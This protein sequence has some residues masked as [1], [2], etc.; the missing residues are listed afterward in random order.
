MGGRIW[1]ESEEETTGATFHVRLPLTVPRMSP[2]SKGYD[3]EEDEEDEE[4]SLFP[5]HQ[6]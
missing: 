2:V 4:N 6:T 5:N 1:A 3:E